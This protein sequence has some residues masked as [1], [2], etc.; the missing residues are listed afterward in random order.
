MQEG[1]ES[2][3]LDGPVVTGE[4]EEEEGDEEPVDPAAHT[5]P[6]DHDLSPE[7]S[8]QSEADQEQL[9]EGQE[10]GGEE[11]SVDQ[12]QLAEDSLT[13]I[14]T[15]EVHSTRIHYICEDFETF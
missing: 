11:E 13:N 2:V 12:Q 6:H 9:A 7:V 10:E 3:T 15:L 1:A 8:Y 14:S 4:P 5:S